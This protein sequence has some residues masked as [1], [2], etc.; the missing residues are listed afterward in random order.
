MAA[1]ITFLNCST[2]NQR[3]LEQAKPEGRRNIKMSFHPSKLNESFLYNNS[4]ITDKTIVSNKFNDYFV[5]VGKTFAAQIT[6]S[7]PSF[8]TYLPEANKE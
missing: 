4:V 2:D 6:R 3:R 8:H 1:L 7:G 5:N